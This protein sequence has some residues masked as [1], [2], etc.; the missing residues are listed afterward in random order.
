M[1]AVIVVLYMYNDNF[2]IHVKKY[3]DEDGI[4]SL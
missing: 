4:Q 2:S 3:L 1:K